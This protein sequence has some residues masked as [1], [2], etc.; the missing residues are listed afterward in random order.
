MYVFLGGKVHTYIYLK[1]HLSFS[2]VDLLLDF[3][4][5]TL[6]TFSSS[7]HALSTKTPSA[8]F[9]CVCSFPFRVLF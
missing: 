1:T 6:L 7:F 3:L 4:L 9:C 2:V 8:G 5:P